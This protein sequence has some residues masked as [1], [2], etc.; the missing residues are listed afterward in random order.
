MAG[1]ST[2]ESVIPVRPDDIDMNQHVHNSKYFDYVLAARYD[3]MERC[4]GMSMEAFLERGFSWVVRAS[5]ME[6]KRPLRIG[7]QAV[8]KTQV[9][10]IRSRGV[11]VGFRIDKGSDQK[12]VAKGWLDYVM[13]DAE[14]GRPKS[15][16]EDVIEL[17][18][19]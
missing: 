3:Q 14:T 12:A 8:V 16:P 1:Y 11:K 19:V 6:H 2:F 13:V 9:E 17:Y 10:E 5:Y 15:I 18:S 4:Y 7:D